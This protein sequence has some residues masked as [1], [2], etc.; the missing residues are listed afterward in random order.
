MEHSVVG[1]HMI[2]YINHMSLCKRFCVIIL[3]Y[4]N[5]E[6]R[7]LQRVGELIYGNFEKSI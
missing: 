6:K 5:Q 4:F 2:I 1:N 3:A 7:V